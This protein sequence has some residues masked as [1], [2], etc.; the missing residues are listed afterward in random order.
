MFE[1]ISSFQLSSLQLP[2][3]QLATIQLPAIAAGASLIVEGLLA[4]HPI[5]AIFQLLPILL[6]AGAAYYAWIGGYYFVACLY[7]LGGML[8][9][10]AFSSIR[11][12]VNI[13]AVALF[14]LIL[15]STKSATAGIFTR[16]RML[17]NARIAS[18]PPRAYKHA[19]K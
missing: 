11:F 10:L 6:S 17:E 3:V 18:I 2:A 5:G 16:K 4:G 19:T 8:A 1:K 7:A 13:P 12:L 9:I 15:F 14:V